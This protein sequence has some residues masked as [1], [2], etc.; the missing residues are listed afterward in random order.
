MSLCLDFFLGFQTKKRIRTK[1]PLSFF[2][3]LFFLGFSHPK[4][5]GIKQQFR[6]IFLLA[7]FLGCHS[8]KNKRVETHP[9]Y[10]LFSMLCMFS[11]FF[12]G[13]ERFKGIS[14]AFG[15]GIVPRLFFPKETKDLNKS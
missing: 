11:C 14:K 8:Q 5:K 2:F 6:L 10:M 4:N 1:N 13:A 3:C 7:Y 12:P 9:L 15:F